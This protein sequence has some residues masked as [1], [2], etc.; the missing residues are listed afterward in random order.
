[1]EDEG[2]L[3]I[4]DDVHMQVMTPFVF[5]C[6]AP[7]NDTS[8]FQVLHWVFLPRIQQQLD[9][10]TQAWNNHRLTTMKMTPIEA[11]DSMPHAGTND[12]DHIEQIR[13]NVCA[14]HLI[15]SSVM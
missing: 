3:D 7:E 15:V 13:G 10:F 4:D 9:E 8:P 5:V 2:L 6:V 1:M 12:D 14:Q 11:M